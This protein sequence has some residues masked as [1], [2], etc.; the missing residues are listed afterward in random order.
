MCLLLRKRRNQIL[1]ANLVQKLF[2]KFLEILAYNFK[3]AI[4]ALPKF[5]K[6]KKFAWQFVKLGKN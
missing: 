6:L 4:Y 1:Q 2:A 5:L 3:F